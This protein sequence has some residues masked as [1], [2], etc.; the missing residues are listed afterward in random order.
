MWARDS[1]HIFEAEANAI[2]IGWF[3]GLD[4]FVVM[5]VEDTG[6]EDI[7]PMDLKIPEGP[8]LILGNAM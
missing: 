6:L 3:L 1:L 4:S 8:R 2:I 7:Q 5:E